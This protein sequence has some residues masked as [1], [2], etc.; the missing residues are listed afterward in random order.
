ML[1]V[2]LIREYLAKIEKLINSQI[3][4]VGRLEASGADT[5]EA[6][7]LLACWSAAHTFLPN[8]LR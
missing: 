2:A 4:L 1:N 6:E 8:D 7:Q 3:T 5:T